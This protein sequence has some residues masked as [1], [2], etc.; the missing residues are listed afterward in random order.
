MEASGITL[1]AY[2]I[3]FIL[4]VSLLSSYIISA[5]FIIWRSE[6]IWRLPFGPNACKS[7]CRAV[8][9][10]SFADFFT[11][12]FST[13]E[14]ASRGDEEAS[15]ITK[16]GN[17]V[18]VDSIVDMAPNT[19]QRIQPSSSSP[20]SVQPPVGDEGA[21]SSGYAKFPFPIDFRGYGQSGD[22]VDIESG[23]KIKVDFTLYPAESYIRE[24]QC[25]MS[26]NTLWRLKKGLL[27][28][29]QLI[30]PRR[31]WDPSKSSLLARSLEEGPISAQPS[32][33]TFLSTSV[34]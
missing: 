10:L 25:P 2:L 5:S 23:E 9:N 27:A 29:Q 32:Y 16:V 7:L 13:G 28:A 14:A 24:K 21:S 8:S 34:G 11:S 31:F 17:T 30:S 12:K 33:S 19:L 6:G 20:T 4:V 15:V 22:S 26:A 18:I 3:V 1:Q